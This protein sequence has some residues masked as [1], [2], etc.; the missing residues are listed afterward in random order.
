M[1]ANARLKLD[2]NSRIDFPVMIPEAFFRKD[3]TSG[4]VSLDV[5]LFDRALV[6]AAL[7]VL[8]ERE[9]AE[10]LEA[11][12]GLTTALQSFS[13]GQSVMTNEIMRAVENLAKGKK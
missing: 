10:Q 13:R 11:M 7:L 3:E 5:E 9:R 4:V 12:R 1:F 2:I 6:K 8:E